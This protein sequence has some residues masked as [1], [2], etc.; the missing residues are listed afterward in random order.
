MM[1][2]LVY[3]LNCGT[4]DR[5]HMFAP[6]QKLFFTALLCLFATVVAA[7]LTVA[8]V[9]SDNM[10]L[11]REKPV[12][13]WGK[14]AAGKPVIVQFATQQKTTVADT[15]G[16][17]QIVFDPFTLSAIPQNLSMSSGASTLVLKNILVG[18]VWLCSGQSNME[19]TLDRKLKKYAAPKRGVDEA[20]AELTKLKPAGIRYLYVERTLNKIPLLPTQ[21]W[22]DGNDTMVRYA[23]AIGYFFAKDIFEKTNVPIGII[24]STWGG[25]RIEQW[26]PDWSYRQSSVFRDSATSVNFKI[27]GIH[28]GQMYNGL[29]E[30]MVPFA[31]KGVLWYQGESNAMIEDQ[32]TYPAKFELLVN[33]WRS[34]FKDNS[35]PFYYVQVAPFSYSSRKDKKIHS[36]T[37]LPEFWEAQ[38]NSMNLKNVG[39]VV[40]TDL[41]DNF[42]DIHPSYKWT[43]GRR[44]ALWALEK[45]YKIKQLAYSGPRYASS[46]RKKHSFILRFDHTGTGLSSSDGKDLNWFSI[47]GKDGKFETAK[48]FIEGDKVIVSS[49]NIRRPAMVRFAWDEKAQ[50][51]LVNKEG[52]PALPFRTG[53]K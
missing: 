45:D 15:A 41:V 4:I 8:E 29:I 51:N 37:L 49:P 43:V 53:K 14:A 9:F 25:T 1:P 28:P 47:A 5:L 18:D 31:I 17:W 12:I 40:T 19:Y 32:S 13:V 21:G 46:K 36:T 39:M 7:Q 3:N 42:T 35:L 27:D 44:L 48:A 2:A 11:Q 34:L 52:L 22:T 23:S 26:Q 16:K 38:S 30:P 50:P 6:V 10:V 33:T 24:S 20:E